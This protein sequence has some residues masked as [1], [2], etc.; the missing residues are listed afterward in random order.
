[1][2]QAAGGAARSRAREPQ[3]AERVIY[4]PGR[5]QKVEQI[6]M[7]MVG[8]EQKAQQGYGDRAKIR[9]IIGNRL[10]REIVLAPRT[11]A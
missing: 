3:V 6:M 7:Q 11:G 8:G 10:A 4:G 9:R 5:K 1:V 2:A